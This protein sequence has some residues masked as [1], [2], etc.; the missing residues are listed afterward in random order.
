M[1]RVTLKN[2]QNI[3]KLSEATKNKRK[4]ILLYDARYNKIV[5]AA[6]LHKMSKNVINIC[7]NLYLATTFDALLNV[8][9]FHKRNLSVFTKQKCL[10]KAK[11]LIYSYQPCLWRFLI[12]QSH[13]YNRLY[14]GWSAETY[15]DEPCSRPDVNIAK[16]FQD[17]F[18]FL[19]NYICC[20]ISSNLESGSNLSC[21]IARHLSHY[22]SKIENTINYRV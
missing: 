21:L 13:D 17:S 2:M 19:Q 10:D 4:R 8:P 14:Y 7:K 18:T 6:E 1:T 5:F 3:S 20:K 16:N 9:L 11:N 22:Q 15:V 12:L